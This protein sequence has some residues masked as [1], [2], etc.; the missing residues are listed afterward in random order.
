[1]PLAA[2]SKSGLEPRKWLELLVKVRE[3]EGRVRGPLFC[4]KDGRVA[5]TKEYEETFHELLFEI[6]EARPD[7]IPAEVDVFEDF[8]LSRSL[9]RGS[10]TTAGRHGVSSATVELIN[11]W[12]KIENAKGMK[13]ALGMREH[14]SDV[15]QMLSKLLIYSRSL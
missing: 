7:L 13:P 5:R 9:R 10:A 2:T 3:A 14:Y 6:K 1:M 12:R 4:G 15:R 8:G 11:R